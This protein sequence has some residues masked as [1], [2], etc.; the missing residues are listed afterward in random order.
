MTDRNARREA[1]AIVHTYLLFVITPGGSDT[2]PGFLKT[3]CIMKVKFFQ[4]FDPIFYK[5]VKAVNI[6]LT[7]EEKEL[8][9]SGL[10]IL[11]KELCIGEKLKKF[12]RSYEPYEPEN[13][14]KDFPNGAFNTIIFEDMYLKAF[15]D[16]IFLIVFVG[17]IRKVRK[18]LSSS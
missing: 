17:E 12:L 15:S 8:F 1:V 9:E 2:L 4:T 10:N 14:H 11:E 3:N 16:L 18:T 5:R 13:E 6:I 7:P